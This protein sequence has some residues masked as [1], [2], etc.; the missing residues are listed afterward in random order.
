MVYP[1]CLPLTL[2]PEFPDGKINIHRLMYFIQDIP[3]RSL[4]P[5]TTPTDTASHRSLPPS[6]LSQSRVSEVHSPTLLNLD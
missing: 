3:M 2:V 1:A 5:S 6:L 4:R